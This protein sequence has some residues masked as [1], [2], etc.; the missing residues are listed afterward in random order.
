MINYSERLNKSNV[1]ELSTI[2]FVKTEILEN[3]VIIYINATNSVYN[4]NLYYRVARIKRNV[5]ED[6][7]ISYDAIS[8]IN[9]IE[10]EYKNIKSMLNAIIKA[11][12]E[13][14]HSED[15]L[16]W[17][18]VKKIEAEKVEEI[19]E[20]NNN[21]EVPE[22][23]ATVKNKINTIT[24]IVY[25]KSFDSKQD[26]INYCL[27]NDFDPELMIECYVDGV[28]TV[29]YSNE[30]Y[31]LE[32]QTCNIITNDIDSYKS[33]TLEGLNKELKRFINLYS[34]LNNEMNFNNK[35][36]EKYKNNDSL[37]LQI[38]VNDSIDKNIHHET[39]LITVNTHI[40]KLKECIVTFKERYNKKFGRKSP[41]IQC[42][43]STDMDCIS[44][45]LKESNTIQVDADSNKKV[46]NK[47]IQHLFI[48]KL[49][50][51][52]NVI[53]Y[54]NYRIVSGYENRINYEGKEVKE[55]MHVIIYNTIT[56]DI[57]YQTGSNTR[58]DKD[59]LIKYASVLLKIVEKYIN[60][61]WNLNKMMDQFFVDFKFILFDR[62]IKE[63]EQQE[64]ELKKQAEIELFNKENVELENK[65]NDIC[66]NKEL[67]LIKSY[68]QMYIINFSDKRCNKTIST[69]DTIEAIINDNRYKDQ[70]KLIY[71]NDN[72]FNYKNYNTA[73]K[74]AINNIA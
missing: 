30:V 52:E 6:N 29:D 21:V 18:S 67:K 7:T 39:M 64:L 65:L 40:N 44:E 71:S 50:K 45:E 26:A 53:D 58:M 4:D 43:L 5:W 42:N 74:E 68:T 13:M 56:N 57:I 61:S 31:P 72:I 59:I 32:F 23:V 22:V 54:N 47:S 60:D 73:L 41:F 37:K 34:N 14:D 33:M 70:Y 55:A 35:Q 3:E 20:D 10:K 38:L 62:I 16:N 24:Y 49:F 12:N 8:Y 1:K 25:N 27:D 28:K 46:D 11:Y 48:T 19:K 2:N 66:V 15:I 51:Y 36:I 63:Y 17:S 9:G 69:I